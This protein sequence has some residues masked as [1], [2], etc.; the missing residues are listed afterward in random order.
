MW[1]T[2]YT[3]GNIFSTINFLPFYNA[4]GGFLNDDQFMQSVHDANRAAQQH[5][6]IDPP[7]ISL[8]Q[9]RILSVKEHEN[10]LF[11]EYLF[12]APYGQA[13][14]T[15]PKT[16]GPIVRT[17]LGIAANDGLV[18]CVVQTLFQDNKISGF[19]RP[20]AEH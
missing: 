12:E 6:T 19:R 10:S 11:E 14:L 16:L 15:L 7:T 18:G 20:P 17:A 13:I 1:P 9:S 8:Y 4:N 5:Q 3:D 2:V